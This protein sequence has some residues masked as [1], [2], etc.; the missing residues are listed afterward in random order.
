MLAVHLSLKDLGQLLGSTTSRALPIPE[1]LG[2]VTLAPQIL[3]GL[4]HQVT[5]V[6]HCEGT[7]LRDLTVRGPTSVTS[8]WEDPPSWTSVLPGYVLPWMD[9]W[10]GVKSMACG[11]QLGLSCSGQ[12]WWGPASPWRNQGPENHWLAAEQQ[13]LCRAPFRT[14]CCWLLLLM[15]EGGT[16][17]TYQGVVYESSDP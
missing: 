14:F 2:G 6:L 16:A 10:W 5:H 1:E 15:L 11:R 4:W 3:G 7:H 17:I 9:A 13:Q 12:R 8:P